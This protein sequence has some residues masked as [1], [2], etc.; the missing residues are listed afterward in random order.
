MV[1]VILLGHSYGGMVATGVADRVLAA[2]QQHGEGWRVPANPMPVD[3]SAEDL[4]W[5]TPRRVMQPLKIF[6]Q[7]IK[8]TGAIDTLPRAYIYCKIPGPG[9][10]FRQFAQRAQTEAGWTYAE[11]QAS[12]NPH[13][14]MPETL[15]QLLQ[16]LSADK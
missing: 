16:G 5:A 6:E 10:V 1:P 13:I 12:H 3:T 2:V 9:D 11:L 7:A 4:Q 15:M 14:T 8:L